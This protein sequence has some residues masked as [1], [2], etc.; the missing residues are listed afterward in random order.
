[1]MLSVSFLEC[2]AKGV[3][4]TEDREWP[5]TLGVLD[6]EPTRFVPNLN[7]RNGDPHGSHTRS[8]M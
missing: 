8:R 1:M 2:F 3:K 6:R 7:N 5:G 4:N